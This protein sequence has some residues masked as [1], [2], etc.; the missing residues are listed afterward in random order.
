[1]SKAN[2]RR[3]QAQ[4]ALVRR[5][6]ATKIS[7]S[8]ES[9]DNKYQTDIDDEEISS[10]IELLLS[11][12]GDLAKMCKSKCNTKYLSILLYMSLRFFNIKCSSGRYPRFL[13]S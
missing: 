3:N 10:K 12:I 1:M 4:S 8:S 13:N 11:D 6:S 5:W 9:S 2:Q 7:D